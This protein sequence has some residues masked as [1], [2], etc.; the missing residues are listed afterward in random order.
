MGEKGRVEVARGVSTPRTPMARA[1]RWARRGG[2]NANGQAEP[3]RGSVRSQGQGGVP[4]VVVAVNSTIGYT[5]STDRAVQAGAV[6]YRKPSQFK[7]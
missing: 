5:V 1:R 4:V 7:W 2:R 6:E 3:N